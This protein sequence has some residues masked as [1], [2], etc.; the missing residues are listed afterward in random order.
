[1]SLVFNGCQSIDSI[2]A[3]PF[4]SLQLASLRTQVALKDSGFIGM[5][6]YKDIAMTQLI[7]TL[8]PGLFIPMGDIQPGLLFGASITPAITQVQSTTSVTFNFTIENELL[9]PA[10]L[11]IN[12]PIFSGALLVDSNLT[13]T[14]IDGSTTATTGKVVQ[15]IRSS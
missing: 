2:G 5:N 15:G 12:L 1:M 8:A 3:T 13:I 14:S 11:R 10:T 9:G 6:I 7:A 4:G